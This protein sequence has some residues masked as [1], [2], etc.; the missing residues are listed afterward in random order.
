MVKVK[1]DMTGWKMWEHGIPDSRLTVVEQIDDYI[2]PSGEHRPQWLCECNCDKHTRLI[3][4]GQSLRT[5]HIK[6]CG[7]FKRES[8]SIKNKEIFCKTNVYDLN[9]KD[10]HGIYGIGYCSNSGEPFYFD[11]SDYDKIKDYCW[12]ENISKDGYHSLRTNVPNLRSSI[13]MHYLI[14]EKYVDHIDRNPLNNRKSNL[15]KASAT[16]NARNRSVQRNNKSGFTGVYFR[17]DTNK[18]SSH[19]AIEK[20]ISKP[21]GCFTNKEDAIKAR[22][23]AEAK[24]FGKFAPQRHL[25]KEYGIE[26]ED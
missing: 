12:F 16:E 17:Q 22:L 20:G 21:L 7:C 24:Y 13:K 19:I 8:T 1:T 26:S 10:E 25:F 18:W 4:L 3:V 23:E 6:S 11:M 5:G 2:C 14:T 9:L 15:R